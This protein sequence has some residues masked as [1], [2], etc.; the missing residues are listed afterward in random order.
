MKIGP[1]KSRALSKLWNSW[2]LK[3]WESERVR[4]LSA[5]TEFIT[6]ESE[7]D[8]YGKRIKG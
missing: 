6:L 3:R 8:F 5:D 4:L 2:E 7:N 1:F